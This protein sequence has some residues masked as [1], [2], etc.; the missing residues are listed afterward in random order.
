MCITENLQL[1]DHA[2]YVQIMMNLY[3]TFWNEAVKIYILKTEIII[4]F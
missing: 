3:E 4:D 2:S 1:K